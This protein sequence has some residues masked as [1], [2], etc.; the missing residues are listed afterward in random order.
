MEAALSIKDKPISKKKNEKKDDPDVEVRKRLAAMFPHMKTLGKNLVEVIIILEEIHNA[1][2]KEREENRMLR[3]KCDQMKEAHDRLI[4]KIES[5]T[6]ELS[7]WRNRYQTS[8]ES[9]TGKDTHSKTV[10]DLHDGTDTSNGVVLKCDAL[11]ESAP[12][13]NI[14]IPLSSSAGNLLGG[15]S[16]MSDENR[17]LGNDIIP[18]NLDPLSHKLDL[19]RSFDL[20]NLMDLNPSEIDW[21]ELMRPDSPNA[22][23]FSRGA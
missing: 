19:N 7:L 2:V 18:P 1:L 23:S 11:A 17:V 22:E 6:N 10:V 5:L 9:T 13:S 4:E 14:A 21:K 8:P 15:N 12:P 20:E 16:A 3:E